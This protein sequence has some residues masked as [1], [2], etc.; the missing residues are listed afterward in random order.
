MT[1]TT[2]VI[3]V[4]TAV[5][6]ALSA[7]FVAVEF[8]ILG[9]KRHR[10]E[11]AAERSRAARAALRNATDMTMLLAGAQ[12]G[13]TLCALGLG[14]LTK[15][16][17]KAWLMP[18]LLDAGLPDSTA[19]VIAFL[20]ALLI[21]T[22]LHLVIG[23]MAPKSWA[24]SHPEFSATLL[25]IPM[26]GFMR[27]MHLPL[28]A[29]NQTANWMMMRV[30]VH[31]VD[32]VLTGQDPAG[33]RHLVEHSVNVGALDAGFSE[34]IAGVLEMQEDTVRSLVR[35]GRRLTMV[36]PDASVGD[37]QEAARRTGHL[38][39]LVGSEGDVAG[40][41]HVRDTL[42]HPE[43]AG[44]AEFTRP[45]FTLSANTKLHSALAAMRRS[46]TH[47]VLVTDRGKIIGVMSLTDILTHVLPRP[48]TT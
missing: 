44:V 48:V 5:L 47:L 36:P 13:I 17:V 18:P 45:I 38:R 35:P 39:V 31:P 6:I 42:M 25:S 23:E 14:A 24:I 41:V 22:F 19:V 12:L 32:A 30:G 27:V 4:A 28:R 40:V 26:R 8:A 21:V 46:R 20:L 11:E 7:F 34:Q 29:L 1:T 43:S 10:L 37:I 2:I 9:V 33:L 15:P 3:I 16:A